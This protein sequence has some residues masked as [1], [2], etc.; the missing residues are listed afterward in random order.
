MATVNQIYSLVNAVS[1]EVW[2]TQ[3]PS[4]KDLSGL[5]SLGESVGANGTW[6][7]DSD[8][9]L[10]ALVDRIGKSVIRTLDRRVDLPNFIMHDFEFGAIL[11]KIDVQPIEAVQDNSWNV[12]AV[13][14]TS[15][16]LNV[17]KPAVSST[18]FKNFNT[19]TVKTTIPD[20][21]FKT[22]FT[23]ADSMSAFITAILDS[24]TGSIESQINK[25]NHICICNFF[26]EKS[27]NYSNGFYG[28]VTAYNTAMGYTSESAGYLTPNTEAVLYNK[29]FIKFATRFI[30]NIVKFMGVEGTRFN[31][32]S[33]IR[34]TARDNMHC[35]MLTDF[36]SSVASYLE[37][38]TYHNELVS[39]PYYDEVSYWQYTG[40]TTAYRSSVTVVPS[41]EEGQDSPTTVSLQYIVGCLLDRQALGTTIKER[42]S[43]SDRFNSERRTNYTEGIN[44]GWFN[45]L[46]E[47]G[48]IFTLG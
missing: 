15:E 46:S 7:A 37:S 41:S 31:V 30:N 39:L 13:D 14:F 34:A 16:Y 1:K 33:K 43:A 17:Y 18:L 32:G 9:F 24:L 22:A 19:W 44:V 27:K 23:S 47:N 29:D 11:Q 12:G 36:A 20:V 6:T 4:V 28:L 25:M 21:M 8:K 2:G 3:S 26:A 5:I 40:D 35:I 10:G 38:D 48:A 45:D 42:W